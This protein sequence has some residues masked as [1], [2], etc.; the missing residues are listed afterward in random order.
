M[1]RKEEQQ[2]LMRGGMELNLTKR[3]KDGIWILDLRGRLVVGDSKVMLRRTIVTMTG[4]GTL[5]VVINLARVSEIDADGLGTLVSCYAHVQRQNGALKLL[6][7]NPSHLNLMVAAR[8]AT[9][10]EVFWEDQD[11][12]NSFFPDRVVQSYG[13]PRV[14]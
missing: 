6:N 1:K 14:E 12:V 8:L 2:M 7:P 3:Q 4:G 10:F 13:D 11:A 5:K 9:V